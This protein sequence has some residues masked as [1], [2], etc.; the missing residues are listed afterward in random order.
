MVSRWV[1]S[2]AAV[3][4]KSTTDVK[5]KVD[6][7][8]EDTPN[9]ST[10][11]AKTSESVFT[12]VPVAVRIGTVSKVGLGVIEGTAVG[13]SLVDVVGDDDGPRV[14][15]PS[16]NVTFLSLRRVLMTYF[17]PSGDRRST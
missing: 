3:E 2:T 15:Q 16:F 5:P 14:T 11:V 6:I 4:P 9:S 8:P 17:A 10:H 7:N 13:I 12:F 1:K